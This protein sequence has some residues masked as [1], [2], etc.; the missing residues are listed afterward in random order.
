MESKLINNN[1]IIKKTLYYVVS[2]IILVIVTFC[3]IKANLGHEIYPSEIPI[4]SLI[5]SAA[6]LLVFAGVIIFLIKVDCKKVFFLYFTYFL[7]ITLL[8]LSNVI[9]LMFV[10][11][12]ADI[13]KLIGT[14]SGVFSS[15]MGGFNY[16]LSK[17]F[18]VAYYVICAVISIGM[19]FLLMLPKKGKSRV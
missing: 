15:A 7:I 6:S 4:S 3:A 14:L 11:E 17:D 12:N 13:Y 18:D 1:G 2:N 8:S 19:I 9:M 16:F 10:N 5:I